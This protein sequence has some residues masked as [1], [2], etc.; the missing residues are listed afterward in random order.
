MISVD[1]FLEE[2]GL[3]QLHE[4]FEKH[5]ITMDKLLNI[6]AEEL[7]WIGLKD[8]TQIRI[9]MDALEK[10]KEEKAVTSNYRKS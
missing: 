5:E 4:M 10:T 3:Q 9:I 2:I 6:S 7:Q 8:K 1:D